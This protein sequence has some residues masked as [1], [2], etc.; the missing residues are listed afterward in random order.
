[1]NYRP[2]NGQVI[3]MAFAYMSFSFLSLHRWAHAYFIFTIAVHGGNLK[4]VNECVFHFL[5]AVR[6]LNPT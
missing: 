4:W 3:K 2:R 1:M 6:E 5:N